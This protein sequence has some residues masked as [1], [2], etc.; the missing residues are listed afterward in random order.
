VSRHVFGQGNGPSRAKTLRRNRKIAEAVRLE[1]ERDIGV[2][3]DMRVVL[4]LFD[5]PAM[6][7]LDGYPVSAEEYFRASALRWFKR[8]VAA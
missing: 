6:Y 2:R 3:A 8:S 1:D 7:W 5:E 4:G